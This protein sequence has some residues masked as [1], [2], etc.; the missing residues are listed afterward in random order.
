MFDIWHLVGFACMAG[1]LALLLGAGIGYYAAARA[2]EKD[3]EGRRRTVN[4]SYD[5]DDDGS[6]T[7]DGQNH[8]RIFQYKVGPE[9]V[10]A[11]LDEI[12]VLNDQLEVMGMRGK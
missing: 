1:G 5:Y 3:G 9:A 7:F 2:A 12:D 4:E 8:L 11:L 10:I 6:Y